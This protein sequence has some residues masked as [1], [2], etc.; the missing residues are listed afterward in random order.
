MFYNIEQAYYVE[1]LL[2]EPRRGKLTLVND[3]PGALPSS[4]RSQ[5]EDFKAVAI[6]I[7]PQGFQEKATSAA[8]IEDRSS[9][10]K[11]LTQQ[12]PSYVEVSA[13][14]VQ[15]FGEACKVRFA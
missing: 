8:H 5:M 15:F 14:F 11:G 4:L 13:D 2:I 10:R 1:A 3:D 9:S 12:M 7:L 6:P